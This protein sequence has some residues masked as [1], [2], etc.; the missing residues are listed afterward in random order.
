MIL[1][2]DFDIVTLMKMGLQHHSFNVYGFTDPALAIEHFRMN[3]ESY[4]LVI[5]DIRM[6]QMN[7]FEFIK[8]I[9]EI[10]PEIKVFLMTAFE[11]N[12]IE[13]RKL[14]S[15]TRIDEFIS[16]PISIERLNTLVRT[17]V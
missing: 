2:D 3:A 14:L 9:K 15:S 8:K 11:I 5:S 16:K 13:F 17:H 7:G 10:K 1:D 4:D 12:D 6:P